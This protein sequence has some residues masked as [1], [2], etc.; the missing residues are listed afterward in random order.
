[1]VWT[2]DGSVERRQ[3]LPAAANISNLT[4]PT[5]TQPSL[6]HHSEVRTF[7]H[8]FGHVIHCICSRAPY[9]LFSWAWSAV[10]YAAG[11]ENDFL[12]VPSLMLENWMWEPT[13]LQHIS[14]AP[15]SHAKA[16]M[17]VNNDNAV[18][19]STSAN[20]DNAAIKPQQQK[21]HKVKIP[22]SPDPLPPKYAQSLIKSRFALSG[23]HYSRQLFM[24]LY[25]LR[26]HSIQVGE[27]LPT[28]EQLNEWWQQMSLELTGMKPVVD[29]QPM[30]SWYHLAMG[31]DA[32]YYGYLWSELVS[33]DMF[34][35]KWAKADAGCLDRQVGGEY[36][37]LV[38]ESGACQGGK[39]ISEAFLGRAPNSN[40]LLNL[41]GLL[42]QDKQSV[43]MTPTTT[44]MSSTGAS[45]KK[46]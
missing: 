26:I 34:A 33:A 37:R 6:L 22:S 38:L 31:Y 28:A 29:T 45:G 43:A 46:K 14:L 44:V 42:P 11:V 1:M 7:F 9:T 2:E 21:Q 35:S 16:I 3:Q 5:A 18:S 19:N 23:Y 4:P 13:I 17:S 20:N 27:P 39:E 24:T 12:E 25:D 32:G 40:A 8:E 15:R 36:R 10:P 41:L 30:A